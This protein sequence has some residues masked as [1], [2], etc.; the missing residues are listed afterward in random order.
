MSYYVGGRLAEISLMQSLLKEEEKAVDSSHAPPSYQQTCT[1]SDQ[2]DA[3]TAISKVDPPS[4]ANVDNENDNNSD[5]SNC[6]VN[7]SMACM[8]FDDFKIEDVCNLN[9]KFNE[10][11]KN[12][13]HKS[14]SIDHLRSECRTPTSEIPTDQM[15]K[16]TTSVATS[17]K[18]RSTHHGRNRSSRVGDGWF[19]AFDPK[20][21]KVFFFHPQTGR[22][23]WI[24]PPGTHWSEGKERELIESFRNVKTT[25]KIGSGWWAAFDLERQ[26]AFFFHPKSGEKTWKQPD[27]TIWTKEME[28]LAGRAALSSNH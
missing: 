21:G 10:R 5:D 12:D 28:N 14:R 25:Q 16:Q 2:H 8:E 23:T 4:Y 20:R 6:S 26:K 17:V 1:V 7:C 3:K 11:K 13:A 27:G 22:K 18:K 15:N 19:A 9:Q 24:Q